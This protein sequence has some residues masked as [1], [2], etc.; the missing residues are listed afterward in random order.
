VR[1]GVRSSAGMNGDVRGGFNGTVVIT[2]NESMD[3]NESPWQTA[4]CIDGGFTMSRDGALDSQLIAAGNA[5]AG[6]NAVDGSGRLMASLGGLGG[7][8][9]GPSGAS[10]AS[11]SMA[12]MGFSTPLY[13]PPE[14]SNAGYMRSYASGAKRVSSLR[15]TAPPLRSSVPSVA[16]Y[17]VFESEQVGRTGW[18][19]GGGGGA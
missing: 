6:A 2:V 16:T 18:G 5:I 17:M 3:P 7:G 13:L 8:P 9:S 12:D 1:I 11:V 15:S 19:G 4:R 14:L 10:G